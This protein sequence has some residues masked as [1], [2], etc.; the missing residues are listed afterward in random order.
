M[1]VQLFNTLVA[2]ILCYCSEVWGPALLGHVGSGAGLV[3]K[4]QNNAMSRV[5]YLFLRTIAGYLHKS[6]SRLLLAREFGAQPLVRNWL[7]SAVALWNR[8]VDF[9]SS[10]LLARAT[11]ENLQLAGSSG[12]GSLWCVQLERIFAYLQNHSQQLG[13]SVQRMRNFQALDC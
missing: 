13:D 12:N 4:L 8:V 2:P 9:D 1:Q 6:T 11:R 10:S 3:S 7:Q 5:Q